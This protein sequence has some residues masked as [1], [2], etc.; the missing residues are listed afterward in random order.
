MSFNQSSII[1]RSLYSASNSYATAMKRLSTGCRIN[2]ASDD[3]AGLSLSTK[4]SSSISGL[5]V[6]NQ[7][8]QNG[9]SFLNVGDGALSTMTKDVQRIRDLA[10]QSANGVYSNSER[11]ML[12]QEAQQ[13]KTGLQQTIDST[14][15]A[16]KK[17]FADGSSTPAAPT[18]SHMTEADATAAGYI[19]IKTAADFVN[20]VPQTGAGTAGKTY[21]LMGDIDM[22]SIANYIAKTNFAGTFDGNGYTMSNLTIN[23]PALALQGLFG[24]ANNGAKFQN[25]TLNNFNITAGGY[26]GGLLG[27]NWNSSI[28]N[29]VK[30]TNSNIQTT[31]GATGGLVGYAGTLTMNNCQANINV[32]AGGEAGGLIG[33]V[34]SGANISKCS[35]AGSVSGGG[36]VGGILA[37]N[38]GYNVSNITEC[39]NSASITGSP[40]SNSTGGIFGGGGDDWLSMNIRNCYSTGSIT[41]GGGLIGYIYGDL[42]VENCYSSGSTTGAN[43]GGFSGE[44]P[45]SATNNFWNTETSGKN[46]GTQ[47]GNIAGITGITSAQAANS[48]TFISAGFSSAI[49]DFS[50]PG[51]PQLAWQVASTPST[52]TSTETGLELQIGKDNNENSRLAVDTSFDLGTFDVNLGS[53]AGARDAIDQ[54]DKLL[55][56]MVDKQSYFGASLNRL[57]SMLNSQRT[58]SDNLSASKSIIMDTDMAVETAKLMK[59]QILQQVSTN[60]FAKY[61]SSYSDLLLGLLK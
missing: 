59:S 23:K 5:N 45:T 24:T 53:V 54:C 13:L 57:G 15:F 8:T 22:S 52:P 7:N 35:S 2:G 19:V 16:D 1:Q 20:L 9:I 34:Y 48:S 40:F 14:T 11:A 56:D 18:V 12:N 43:Y 44:T 25:V 17:I 26:S 28:V 30:I 47:Y 49:W 36:S 55:K 21:M 3:A 39:S 33:R 37:N 58:T 41:N 29:N 61:K 6:A 51:S 32:S 27:V 4:L 60:L 50:N 38:A 46:N 10:V 31:G 42:T